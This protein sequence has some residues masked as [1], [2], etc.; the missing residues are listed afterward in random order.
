MTN[1]LI[2]NYK[3]GV[4]RLATDRFDFENH[5][6]GKGFRHQAN[7]ID[8]FPTIVIGADT[9]TNVQD[10]LATLAEAVLPPVI[11]NATTLSPGIVQ[12]FGDISGIATNVSVVGLRGRPVNTLV[13]DDGDI[14]TWDGYAGNWGPSALI[15]PFSASGDLSGTSVSQTVIG[16]TGSAGSLRVSCNRIGFISSVVPVIS[17]DTMS[18]NGNNLSIIAQSATGTNQNGGAVIVAGGGAGSGGLRG[19]V[20][21]ELGPSDTTM[22]QLIELVAGRRILSLMGAITTSNMPANTGD[23]V[24][25]INDTVTPPTSGLPVAGTI[26]YSNG[27]QLWVKQADG[28]NFTVGSSPNPTVWGIGGQQLLTQ[29][30]Y[31]TST[32][33]TPQLAYSLTLSDNTATRVEVTFVGKK[34]GTADSAQFTTNMG[35]VRNSA[36]SPVAVGTLTFTDSRTTAG[37][38]GW[39]SPNV[40]TSGN[41]LQVFTGSN[42]ST[43]INWFIVVKLYMSQA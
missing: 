37:A 24:I 27:G 2:P 21:L 26:L 18:S 32:S 8:L 7:Q 16:A 3:S 10:A 1:P 42:A 31:I 13:P 30:A 5:I 41:V 40:T 11:P 6:E 34:Q 29:R 43:T 12:L 4:G 20:S 25:Y 39:I 9:K 22:A 33:A 28:N 38:S 35:Y 15:N 14:L 19:G 23:M 36:G 17:Q